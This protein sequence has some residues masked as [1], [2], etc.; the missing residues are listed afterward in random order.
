MEEKRTKDKAMR[1]SK[2]REGGEE[3]EPTKAP[4]EAVNK[5][6]KTKCDILKWNEDNVSQRDSK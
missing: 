5:V 3:G 2:D 4:G 6:G 1:T